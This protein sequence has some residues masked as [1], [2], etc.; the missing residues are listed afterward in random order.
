[1]SACLSREVN[2]MSTEVNHLVVV[3]ISVVSKAASL[4]AVAILLS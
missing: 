2:Y 3:K 4:E 1:M